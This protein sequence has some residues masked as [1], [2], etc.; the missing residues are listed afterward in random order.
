MVLK[1][2]NTAVNDVYFNRNVG[3]TVVG[4]PTISD[5]VVSG[6]SANDYLTLGGSFS[7]GSPFEVCLRLRFPSAPNT[8]YVV[9]A[10]GFY[11]YLSD[12]KRIS[13]QFQ[14]TGS[15]WVYAGTN[16]NLELNTWYFI[17]FIYDGTSISCKYSLNGIDWIDGTSN[18]ITP[19]VRNIAPNIGYR[20][21]N[22]PFGGEIDIAN[23]FI[24][25]SGVTL[26]NGKETAS[27]AVNTL[28]YNGTTV[29]TR[30][31]E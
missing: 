10:A 11:I 29:W 12:T 17:K 18:P 8:K 21:S 19:V 2:N 5:G 24:K 22:N 23:S 7:T 14:Q 1:F 28:K 3:Y 30:P 16:A 4:S 25:Q 9:A 27:P 13:I 20:S 31:A 6:F 26:F 15:T